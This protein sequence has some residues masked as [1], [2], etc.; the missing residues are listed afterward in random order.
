MGPKKP[1][2]TW[3]KTFW[4]GG[5]HVKQG[6][7]WGEESNLILCS[8]CSARFSAKDHNAVALML[9]LDR[10]SLIKRAVGG[11]SVY[12]MVTQSCCLC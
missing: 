10:E 3:Q 8:A 6:K 5:Q 7:D 12:R 1:G 2:K 4:E 11:S 9:T